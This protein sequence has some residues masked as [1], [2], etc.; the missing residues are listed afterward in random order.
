MTGKVCR[1]AQHYQGRHAPEDALWW[2]E[3][4]DQPGPTG[5]PPPQ[6]VFLDAADELQ[7]RGL[8]ASATALL[9]VLADLL[10]TDRSAALDALIDANLAPG[11]HHG[12]N[13]T[14]TSGRN[15]P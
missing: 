11:G 10:Q 1:F 6:Q 5:A 2:L 9:E 13:T 14:R 12:D 8:H 3:H 7:D 15:C 4:P